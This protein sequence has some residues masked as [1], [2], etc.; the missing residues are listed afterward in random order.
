MPFGLKLS[1]ALCYTCL[2]FKYFSSC[3]SFKRQLGCSGNTSSFI[4]L[5]LD[6]HRAYGNIFETL[7]RKLIREGDVD[8]RKLFD[9]LV[10]LVG[11]EV[12]VLQVGCAV[13][14]VFNIQPQALCVCQKMLT[15]VNKTIQHAI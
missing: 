14:V 8:E 15:T 2:C 1:F 9:I 7:L 6:G 3:F 4:L 12:D 10:D 11:S 5:M 13:Q